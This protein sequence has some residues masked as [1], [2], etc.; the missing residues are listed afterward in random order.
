MRLFGKTVRVTIAGL[1]SGSLTIQG[2]APNAVEIERLQVRFDVKKNLGKHPN[3]CVIKIT[4]LS[5]TTRSQVEQ[6]PL[7]VLLHA[8][9][10]GV[11]KLLF[12]GDMTRAFSDRDG[13]ADV[14]TELHVGDN[15]RAHV[16][17]N[18]VKSYQPPV[19]LRRVV[20]DAAAAMSLTLPPELLKDQRLNTTLD[21]GFSS[22]GP[23]ERALSTLLDPL[24]LSWSS[25]N[26]QLVILGRDDIRPG[27][28]ALLNQSTG[29]IGSPKLK[30]SGKD[31]QK[32]SL[33]FESLLY[34]EIE[35][36][37]EVKIES[38]FLNQSLKA[39]EVTHKGDTHS[40]EWTT[41][42]KGTPL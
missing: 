19:R 29:L 41:E 30:E 9:Y 3:K 6:K 42:G 2:R 21:S 16:F 28:A 27:R 10:D 37:C 26:R 24:G 22:S 14:V 5:Q 40:D 11:L 38:Q 23:A 34:P 36:G 20:Q 35:P 31:G 25:Q 12:D 15:A 18:L 33:S 7:R 17:G 39:E 1:K 13:R 8:G 32:S 4:G